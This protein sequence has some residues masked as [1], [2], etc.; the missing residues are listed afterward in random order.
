MGISQVSQESIVLI[1]K[2]ILTPK[3]YL[4]TLLSVVGGE[5]AIKYFF[6]IINKT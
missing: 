1:P 4:F 5:P 2:S 3:N 6:A